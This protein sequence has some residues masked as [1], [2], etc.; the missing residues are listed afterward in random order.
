MAGRTPVDPVRRPL[1]DQFRSRHGQAAL[2]GGRSLGGV[3]RHAGL[4]REGRAGLRQQQLAQAPSAGHQ[5]GRHAA[6]SPRPTS[7]GATTRERPTFPPSS[8]RAIS[9]SASTTRGVAFC[10]EAATGKVLWQEKLGRHHASPVLVGGLVF[11]IND[12]GEINVIK[13]GTTVRPRRE[14]RAGRAVLRLARDQRRPGLP[15]RL[16]APLLHRHSKQQSHLRAKSGRWDR[17]MMAAIQ[18]AMCQIVC[19]DGDRRGNLARIE[20]A[21]AEAAAI[22]PGSRAFQSPPSS[23]G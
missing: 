21:V 6:T 3:R 18:L 9:C 23:D 16:Q 8:S 5:A 14:V 19:L 20:C 10:Y 11:F 13:P 4:Q 17:K 15:A 1:R 2:D 7:P 12:N 22:G